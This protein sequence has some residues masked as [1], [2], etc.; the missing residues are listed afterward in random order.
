ML[1]FSRL[2]IINRE[3]KDGM[4]KIF[5]TISTLGLSFLMVFGIFT[6]S[7]EASTNNT[8]E[9][10]HSYTK[11]VEYKKEAYE[12]HHPIIKGKVV[13]CTKYQWYKRDVTTCKK[14][15]GEQFVTHWVSYTTSHSHAH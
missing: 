1:Y 6:G 14:H 10:T 8:E 11:K 9:T 12:I 3:E 2:K 7:A 5:S 13:N 4:K 15:P